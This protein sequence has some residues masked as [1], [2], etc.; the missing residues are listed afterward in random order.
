MGAFCER[1]CCSDG[2]VPGG[3]LFWETSE[4]RTREDSTFADFGK[5][6]KISSKTEVLYRVRIVYTDP[7]SF[8][9][10]P[11]FSAGTND[12]FGEKPKILVN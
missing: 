2:S 10:F 11:Y 12:T 3:R 4:A 1:C 8:Y 6:R 5:M 7:F 9:V